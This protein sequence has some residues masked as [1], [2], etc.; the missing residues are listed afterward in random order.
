VGMGILGTVLG[1]LFSS[2][3]S[4]FFT[5]QLAR[6]NLRATQI[7]LEKVETIRL[8]SWSQINTPGF[9]PATFSASYDPQSTNSGL[10]YSGTMSIS[11]APIASSYSNDLKLVTVHVNWQTGSLPRSREFST[12]IARN[13]LQTYIY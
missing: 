2:F 4:G 10:V 9:I 6:E 7:M 5:M 8:Y 12:L 11:S 3:T 13:G 1:A